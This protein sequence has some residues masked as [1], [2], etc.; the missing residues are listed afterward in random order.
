MYEVWD[1]NGGVGDR[2]TE[3]ITG[4]FEVIGENENRRRVVNITGK[5]QLCIVQV[6]L[7]TL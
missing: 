1:L 7:L 2:G 4:M 5:R 3:G 6:E